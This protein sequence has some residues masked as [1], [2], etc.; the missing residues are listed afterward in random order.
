MFSVT[1]IKEY[2]NEQ[3]EPRFSVYYHILGINV[4]CDS[5]SEAKVRFFFEIQ[6]YET[7]IN[8][9]KFV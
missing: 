8:N 2:Y 7:D 3:D 4:T 6:S 1:S 9:L 5:F